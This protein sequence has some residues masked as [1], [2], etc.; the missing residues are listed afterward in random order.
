M[1]DIH[2][3][4]FFGQKSAFIVSTNKKEEPFIFIRYLKRKEDGSWEKPSRKEGKVIKL[5]IEE[6]IEILDI[7]SKN[8]NEWKTIHKFK[9]EMT[10]IS[11]RWDEKLE[12]YWFK[13][14]EYNRLIKRPQSELLK[15]LLEHILEEKIEFA[16]SGKIESAA[17]EPINSSVKDNSSSNE[18]QSALE[19]SDT[20]E[21][22]KGNKN[23]TEIKAVIKKCTEK[24][25]LLQ[26]DSGKEVWTPRSIIYSKYDDKE[27][28]NEQKFMIESW[29]LNK[30]NVKI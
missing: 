20:L 19:I 8:K 25:L 10:N 23:V 2:N 4:G 1:T 15:R 11:M 24:A 6:L 12:G 29:I 5:S 26:F 30:N 13:I 3:Q 17:S 16:T 7:L 14:N 28:S 21:K 9:E 18:T 27:V 22:V